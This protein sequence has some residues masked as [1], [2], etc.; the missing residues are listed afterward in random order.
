VFSSYSCNP[1]RKLKRIFTDQG[2]QDV[3]DDQEHQSFSTILAIS[4]DSKKLKRKPV[5]FHSFSFQ[6]SLQCVY[7]FNLWNSPTTSSLSL[8]FL[9][10]VFQRI[11]R[12][13]VSDIYRYQH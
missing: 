6:S 9:G 5:S 4:S 3:Q 2:V 13:Q 8:C 12:P 7:S 1:R 11:G 10:I